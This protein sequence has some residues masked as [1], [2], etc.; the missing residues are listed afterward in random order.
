M[1]PVRRQL[2]AFGLILAGAA[3]GLAPAAAASPQWTPAADYPL[4]SG[5]SAATAQVGYQTGGIATVA[6]LQMLS[7]AP[8][9]SVLH[10]GTIAPGGVYGEQMQIPSTSS[11]TPT[12]VAVAVAPDGAAVLEWADLDGDTSTS[13][14]SVLASYRPAGSDAWGTPVTIASDVTAVPGES[15]QLVPAI[16][17]AGNGAAAAELPQ[18]G[19]GDQLEADAI[20]PGAGW[21]KPTALGGGTAS[22]RNVALA[23]DGAGDLTAAYDSEIGTS[24]HYT[25]ADQRLPAGGGTW[26]AFEDITGSDSSASAGPPEL[27]VAAD[28]NGVIAF[29]YSAA[30][31]DDVNAV[32][33]MGSTGA[34]SSGQDV[35]PS[36]AGAVSAP[37]AA[38]VSPGDEAYVL[39]S[40][41]FSPSGECVGVIRAALGSAPSFSTPQCVSAKTIAPTA[42]GVAFSAE[43]A[44]FAWSG[45]NS[46]TSPASGVIEAAGW[47]AGAPAPLGSTDLAT[48]GAG[49][50]LGQV[51]SDGAGNVAVLWTT[52]S[53]ALRDAA[54]EVTGPSL[55]ASDIPLFTYAVFDT[56]MNATFADPWSAIST[57][58]SWNFG[59]GQTAQGAQVSHAYST[60]GVYTITVTATNAIGNTTI[61][62][63]RITVEPRPPL[64]SSLR[65]MPASWTERS[66]TTLSFTASTAAEA[67]LTF[68]QLGHARPVSATLQ[69]PVQRGHDRLRF[70]G[71]LSGGRRLVPGRYSLAMTIT[72]GGETSLVKTLTF[73]ILRPGSLSR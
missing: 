71:R 28:G 3:L 69:V 43:D 15:I 7:S 35:V 21:G 37:L 54:F 58:L 50:V 22:A 9:Q 30:G 48:S 4:P 47:P 27:A 33:R 67:L 31:T 34:W 60:P 46:S 49:L 11:A 45:Q 32:T 29:Q 8:I 51:L 61:R 39:Y 5:A 18:S 25:L 10:L 1:T 12:E 66:G 53:N 14:S 13:P 44:R 56:G 17:T 55:L 72:A 42:G 59:D 2:T 20:A 41:Q 73:T 26:G 57:P 68:T 19:G 62:S 36:G 23:Y 63:F 40:E 52:G 38:G 65:A 64:L 24:G 70:Y 16:A 6:Y